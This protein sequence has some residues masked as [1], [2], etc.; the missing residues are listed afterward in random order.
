MT[1]SERH[2]PVS[3]VSLYSPVRDEERKEINGM[4]LDQSILL[5]FII[6]MVIVAFWVLSFFLPYGK[7]IKGKTQ[8]IKAFGIDLEV[9][10]LTLLLL[11]GLP[12][13][14][15]ATV[16]L[17]PAAAVRLAAGSRAGS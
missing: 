1:V 14:L 3:S 8:K 5:L 2:F 10:I 4:S 17:L 6:G 12:T 7:K 9:S 15:L 16:T 13:A 11:V